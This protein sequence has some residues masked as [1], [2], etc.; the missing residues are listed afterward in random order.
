MKFTKIVNQK[1]TKFNKNW[2]NYSLKINLV[3]FKMKICKIYKISYRKK[4]RFCK[5][6]NK[7]FLHLIKIQKK[8]KII[9][10]FLNSNMR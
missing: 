5:N 9:F 1:K 3:K 4:N 8:M 7:K 6:S 10:K 2:K